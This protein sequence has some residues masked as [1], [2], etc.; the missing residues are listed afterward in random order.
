[1]KVRDFRDLKVWQKS[2]DLAADV[3]RITRRFPTDEQFGLTAQVRKATISISSNIAEGNGR[4]STKDYLRFLSI[5]SGSL[6]E[7]RSLFATSGRLGLIRE[8]TADAMESR[9]E[10]ISKMLGALRRSLKRR[11]ARRKPSR[12]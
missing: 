1:M 8:S 4:E 10:E 6:N 9:I 12:T 7:V 2:I 5:S 3:Y 11:I